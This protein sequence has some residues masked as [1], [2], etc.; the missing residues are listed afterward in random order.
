M[1]DRAKDPLKEY[2]A[3][4]AGSETR[5]PKLRKLWVFLEQHYELLHHI[6]VHAIAFAVSCYVLYPFTDWKHI[7]AVPIVTILMA[8]IIT[9]AELPTMLLI[10]VLYA[11]VK[12]ARS[13]FYL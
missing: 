8:P 2:L 6:W 7:A 12:V 5:Q 3:S 4:R 9:I 1:F 11:L 10:S 13:R